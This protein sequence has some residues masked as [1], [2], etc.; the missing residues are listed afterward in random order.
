M[1]AH[2]QRS[3]E[4]NRVYLI[5]LLTN[6]VMLALKLGVGFLTGS[7]VMIA[8]GMDSSLDAIANTIAMVVTRLAGHPPDEEHPYGHRRYETL[9]A[10]L[11]GGFLL[12]TASEIVKS[13]IE[14]LVSGDVPEIGLANFAVMSLALVV[15]LALFRMQRRA[16]QRLHSEVLIASS[17]DKRSD[18]MVSITVLLSLVTVTLGL[19]WVDAVAA[20]V[21]VGLIARNALHIIG[22]SAAILVDHAV[23]DPQDVRQVVADVPGVYDVTRVRSRGTEDDVYLDLAVNVAPPTT[24]DDS[25]AIAEEIRA[26]L[27]TRFEGLSDIDVDFVPATD[28][29]PDYARLAHAEAA[30][31]GLGAHE[32]VAAEMG[33]GLML[34]MHVEVPADM[35]LDEAHTLVSRLEKRLI[36]SLPAVDYVVTHIEP[37]YG[38]KPCGDRDER[39]HH[40]AQQALWIAMQAFPDNQ[41]HDLNVRAEPDGTY[42]LSLHCRIDGSRPVEEAHRLAEAVETRLRSELPGLGRITIRTEPFKTPAPV[43]A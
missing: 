5:S 16:G 19:G 32:V 42:S 14:R 18:I 10:M 17:E 29:P 12:L 15:N 23:L 22:R 30:A 40:L 9:A 24:I 21:V 39:G 6:I 43:P 27:R 13:S 8:D 36:N 41:W 4:V 37:A 33:A 26:R 35:T 20:L 2:T 31:L 34:D 38:I 25:A 28:Q 7:L 3:R 1:T 11:V